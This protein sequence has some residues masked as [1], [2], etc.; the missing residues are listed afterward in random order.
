MAQWLSLKSVIDNYRYWIA[1]PLSLWKWLSKTPRA[2]PAWEGR[3][4]WR[5]T[6]RGGSQAHLSHFFFPF[7]IYPHHQPACWCYW[8]SSGLHKHGQ[9]EDSNTFSLLEEV[10]LLA[11]LH[12]VL[13]L[14]WLLHYHPPT[15]IKT[16]FLSF[17]TSLNNELMRC[18]FRSKWYQQTLTACEGVFSS[19]TN[20]CV[21]YIVNRLNHLYLWSEAICS[22]PV[23]FAG[24]PIS[25]CTT[26]TQNTPFYH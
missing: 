7:A 24:M 15:Q 6:E 26:R 19:K 3:L 20:D 22:L 21:P 8:G 5:R 2:S 18:K 14:R 13:L 25:G 17:L 23:M 11:A 4:Q 12:V 9:H 16:W 10:L 1:R